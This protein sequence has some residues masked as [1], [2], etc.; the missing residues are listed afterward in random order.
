M[1]NNQCTI[2]VS[3]SH[4]DGPD[5]GVAVLYM[6]LFRFKFNYSKNKYGCCILST[7]TFS[8]NL[9]NVQDLCQY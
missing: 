8:M 3:Q 2:Y 5:V 1:D 4:K 6:P 7:L 9:R